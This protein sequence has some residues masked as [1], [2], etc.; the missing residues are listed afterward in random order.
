L[1]GNQISFFIHHRYSLVAN[2]GAP[3]AGRAVIEPSL[4]TERRVVTERTY[5]ELVM[6]RRHK[7]FGIGEMVSQIHETG[8]NGKCRAKKND[9]ESRRKAICEPSHFSIALLKNEM[10]NAF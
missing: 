6:E 4:V 5:Y 9:N 7:S 2:E 10:R 3:L 1:S 8:R